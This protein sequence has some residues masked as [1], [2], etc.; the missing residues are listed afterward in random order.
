MVPFSIDDKAQFDCGVD[1][2]RIRMAE[3]RR[4][5]DGVN[6]GVV[7]VAV[8]LSQMP[9]WIQRNVSNSNRCPRLFLVPQVKSLFI[10]VS[11]SPL[12]FFF[13]YLYIFCF[14]FFS[15]Y[16][17]DKHITTSFFSKRKKKKRADMILNPLERRFIYQFTCLLYLLHI[18][19]R[20]RACFI[21]FKC[22]R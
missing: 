4:I 14:K 8:V 19:P 10:N 17:I 3:T 7:V 22:R 16:V 15:S 20:P 1:R 12:F 13:F 5:R 18:H 2:I 6:G 21:K 9:T 11:A